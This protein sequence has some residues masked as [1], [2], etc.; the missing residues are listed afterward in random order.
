MGFVFVYFFVNEKRDKRLFHLYFPEPSTDSPHE[1][2]KE[3]AIP[4]ETGS[5]MTRQFF[6]LGNVREMFRALTKKRSYQVRLQVLLLFAALLLYLIAYFGPPVFLFQYTQR[7]F[8]WDSQ[9]Y[10]T[11]FSLGCVVNIIS[12]FLWVP[13]L[14]RV[15]I[16]V[17][18]PPCQLTQ[19]FQVLKVSDITL[20]LVGLHMVFLQMVMRLFSTSHTVFYLSLIFCQLN[21]SSSVGIRSYISKIVA[22]SELG[23]ATGIYS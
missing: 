6:D 18:G 21:S 8:Q 2:G 9:Q 13:I 11:Y 12:T 4:V 23:N 15:C 22:P 7:V 17:S 3:E 19:P 10:S 16:S 20:A 14:L 1:N 5:G